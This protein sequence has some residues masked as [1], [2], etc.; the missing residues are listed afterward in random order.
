MRYLIHAVSFLGCMIFGVM[1]VYLLLGIVMLALMFITWSLPLAGPFTWTIFRLAVF[2]S[3]V[4]S[5]MWI[6]SKQNFDFV[7]ETLSD[8]ETKRKDSNEKS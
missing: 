3:F 2:I 8:L 6:G 7:E 1:M 5:V 4:F